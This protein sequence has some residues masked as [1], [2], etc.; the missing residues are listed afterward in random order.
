MSVILIAIGDLANGKL[1]ETKMSKFIN[2][3]YKR[4]KEINKELEPLEAIEK[5]GF[6]GK[7]KKQIEEIESEIFFL[8]IEKNIIENCIKYFEKQLKKRGSLIEGSK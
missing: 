1:G 7:T 3:P 8:V 4:L 5:I 2:N 6:T